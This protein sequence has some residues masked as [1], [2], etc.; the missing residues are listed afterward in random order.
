MWGHTILFTQLW[1]FL[2]RT[3]HLF[4]SSF[5]IINRVLLAEPSWHCLGGLRSHDLPHQNRCPLQIIGVTPVTPVPAIRE[6]IVAP[7]QKPRISSLRRLIKPVCSFPTGTVFDVE[8]E[9]RSMKSPKLRRLQGLQHAQTPR[10]RTS[11]DRSCC[12]RK[13]VFCFC[14]GTGS[15]PGLCGREKAGHI[16]QREH[17]LKTGA[18]I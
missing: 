12:F 3:S 15:V 2:S 4:L 1:T 6:S 9:R 8:K 16:L 18:P 17:H 5:H 13:V 7:F 11:S 10:Q 14:C